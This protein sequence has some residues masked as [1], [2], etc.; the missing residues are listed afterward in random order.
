MRL[1]D[2]V[3]I[4]T[5]GAHGMGE[6]EARLFAAEG[7]KVWLPTSSGMRRRPSRPIFAQAAERPS[8][9]ADGAGGGWNR[10][11]GN[12]QSNVRAP[13]TRDRLTRRSGYSSTFR[14]RPRRECRSARRSSY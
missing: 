11:G 10:F 14:H 3:A 5:G 12:P 7:A 4:V 13:S 6:A 8:A 2:K 9:T 1:K